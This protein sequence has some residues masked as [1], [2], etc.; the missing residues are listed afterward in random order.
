MYNDAGSKGYFFSKDIWRIL[1]KYL[2]TKRDL[3]SVQLAH[4]TF[5][6]WLEEI[7]EVW[8][9]KHYQNYTLNFM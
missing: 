4:P 8:I 5:E 3:I 9:G 1:A 7:H 2:P 6:K